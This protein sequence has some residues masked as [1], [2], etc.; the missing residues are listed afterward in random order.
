MLQAYSTDARV[1]NYEGDEDSETVVV[2]D[3]LQVRKM[4]F[5]L[6]ELIFGNPPNRS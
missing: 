6:S 2:P 5:L 1:T 4:S 3:I